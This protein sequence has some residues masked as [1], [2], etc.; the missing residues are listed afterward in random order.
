L[1]KFRAFYD[2]VYEHDCNCV[3]SGDS[4]PTNWD[5]TRKYLVTSTTFS[6]NGTA[7][8]G[9]STGDLYRY[10]DVTSSWVRAGVSYN[11]GWTKSNI[12]TITGVPQSA[13]PVV[14][15]ARLKEL[16]K[17]RLG[18]FIEINDVAFH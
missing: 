4:T 15:L 12:Y 10:D 7:V 1:K 6:I 11:N 9:H 8:T 3:I 17:F 16:C 2:F 5:T 18:E 13:K 14:A